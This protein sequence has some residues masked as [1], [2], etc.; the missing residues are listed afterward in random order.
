MSVRTRMA[1]LVLALCATSVW[2][3]EQ[4]TG[5]GRVV[6][7]DGEGVAGARVSWGDYGA[8]G[9]A[10]VDA[11]TDDNGRFEVTYT[12]RPPGK[13]R[14]LV[15]VAEGYALAAA[16]GWP[17]EPVTITLSSRMGP[18]SGTAVDPE[19]APLAGVAVR[20]R[21]LGVGGSGSGATV[22]LGDTNLAPSATTD[23]QGQF[24]I[25]ALPLGYQIGLRAER[26][27]LA[28]YYDGDSANWPATGDDVHITMSPEAIITGRVTR[29]GQPAAGV[30]VA[31]QTNHDN[32]R[33]S[34]GWGDAETGEDGSY[35]IHGLPA[36]AYNV[37]LVPP[38]GYTAVAH[39]GV[40]AAAGATAAG[41][42]FELIEGCMLRGTVTWAD[43]GEPAAEASIAAYGPAHPKSSGWVQS[44]KADADGHYE[45]RLPPGANW[46]Y[47][48]GSPSEAWYAEPDQVTVELHEGT[49]QTLD[50][51]LFRKPTITV[52][53]LNPDGQ[54]A[55]GVKVYWAATERYPSSG[56]QAEHVTD[57]RGQVELTYGGR[58]QE[59]TKPLAA[60][61]VQDPERD[62]AGMVI[63]NGETDREA[64][65]ALQQAAWAVTSV[66]DREGNPL[67]DTAV[68][69]R[70][71]EQ[72]WS[73]ELPASARTDA[74]GV[75]RIGPLPAG[76]PL[77]FGLDYELAR[78]VLL[79]SDKQ[80]D[81]IELAAGETRE[82]PPFVVMPEGF[83]VSGLVVDA[84]ANPVAGALVIAGRTSD[85]RTTTNAEGKF[86][87][88]G[89]SPSYDK[90]LIAATPD[91]SAAGTQPVDPMVPVDVTIQLE[92][93]VTIIARVLDDNGQPVVGA[94]GMVYS[95]VVGSDLPGQLRTHAEGLQTDQNGQFT[96]DNLVCGLEYYLYAFT[97][98]QRDPGQ[99]W[100]QRV[101]VLGDQGLVELTLP[102]MDR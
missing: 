29:D 69:A 35:V 45:L 71:D 57:A 91:G 31:A 43:T 30:R 8:D 1:V 85:L 37:A 38:E 80:Q 84:D 24:S 26:A 16:Y 50:F 101:L 63:I 94:T 64:T 41:I 28:D 59:H 3:Q 70:A 65:I 100:A 68:H 87:L 90:D 9:L 53:V 82:L 54:P 42:D 47:W 6:G 83:S 93:P 10:W 88:K 52:T 62:L 51:R 20:V 44:A 4:V 11:T 86:E 95:S 79:S 78:N 2:A 77:T 98:D 49:D 48:M 99:A 56:E 33:G 15:V 25:G 97:G 22:Y 18:I 72:G 14:V 12:P 67:A 92:A 34:Y 36:G 66:E 73:M 23:E 7:P 40:Q 19:G 76:V 46:V 89:L 13:W 96:A 27:G 74:K 102:R 5:S 58:R 75:A 81:P 17:D 60:A 61:L 55:P 21:S 32:D 39:E